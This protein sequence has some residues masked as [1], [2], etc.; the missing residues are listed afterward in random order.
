MIHSNVNDG[1]LTGIES[2]NYD[3]VL[4][5]DEMNLGFIHRGIELVHFRRNKFFTEN[6]LE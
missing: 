2:E 4:I 1:Y 6:H 5:S 3:I